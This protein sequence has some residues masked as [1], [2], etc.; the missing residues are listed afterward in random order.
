VPTGRVHRESVENLRA[1]RQILLTLR[2]GEWRPLDESLEVTPL[3]HM[4]PPLKDPRAALLPGRGVGF[5]IRWVP[6][7]AVTIAPAH[8]LTEKDSI[9]ISPAVWMTWGQSRHS[10]VLLRVPL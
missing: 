8:A 6:H 2:D 9:Q 4:L 10:L 1:P 7:K 5:L 3:H